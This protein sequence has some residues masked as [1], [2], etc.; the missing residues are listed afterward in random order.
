MDAH[1]R[2]NCDV[3]IL[4]GGPAGT[5]TARLLAL[6][7]I[8]AVVVEARDYSGEFMGQTLSPAL[9]P[10]LTQLG[11]DPALRSATNVAC[12]G[13]D[14]AWGGATLCRNDFFW[15]PYG[16][17]W[18]VQRP[19][20]DRSL[21]RAAIEAGAQILC[22][23]RA[24][25]CRRLPRQRWRLEIRS[26]EALQTLYCNCRFVVDATGRSGCAP[27]LRQGRPAVHDRLIGVTWIG[28]SH[29]TYPYTV[30][31]AVSDGWFYANPMPNSRSSV[32]LFTDS[33]IFRDGY[34]DPLKTW[35]RQLQQ[36]KHIR[37]AFPESVES[38]PQRIFSAATI[39]GI[40]TSGP[41]WLS[42][43]DAAMSVDPISGQG[44]SLALNSA[45]HA[46][47]AINKYFRTGSLPRSYETWIHHSFHRYLSVRK[48][49]YS[50]ERR[51]RGSLFWQRRQAA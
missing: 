21:A 12:R 40:P 8:S 4:G 50:I 16:T 6:R 31:E 14:S 44:I 10:F 46:A 3:A 35:R 29:A 22:E 47:T 45:L 39:L 5:T 41:N 30:L 11:L 33:D 20:L 9:N 28:K 42:V 19:A 51:W 17:G 37:N 15:T 1:R 27:R 18:H 48:K 26:S 13:I 24:L 49:Y 23:S 36:A 7:G 2:F 25:S 34:K 32:V 38:Y 43:G